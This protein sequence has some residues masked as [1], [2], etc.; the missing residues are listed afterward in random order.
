M[1]RPSRFLVRLLPSVLCAW[2]APATAAD[3]VPVPG[4]TLPAAAALSVHSD[5]AQL[6]YRLE[7]AAGRFRV[8]IPARVAGEL[9]VRG[10]TA[11]S[12]ATEHATLP[13]PALPPGLLALLPARNQFA[14]AVARHEQAQALCERTRAAVAARLPALANAPGVD[15]AAWQ[16]AIDGWSKLRAETDAELARLERQRL[17]L[18]DQARALAVAG[19][20]APALLSLPE[21]TGGA[22]TTVPLVV[23]ADEL[24][25]AWAA[26]PL[27]EVA[28]RWLLVDLAAAATVT[29]C[30]ERF[31]VTWTPAAELYVAAD[32]HARLVRLARI[33]KPTGLALGTIATAVSTEPLDRGMV[34]PPEIRVQ[35]VG[36]DIRRSTGRRVASGSTSADWER[37]KAA[38]AAAA[39]AGGKEATVGAQLGKIV[40]AEQADSVHDVLTAGQNAPPM[41]MDRI[42]DQAAHDPALRRSSDVPRLAQDGDER[43]WEV[44]PIALPEGVASVAATLA[45]GAVAVQAD[46][47]VLIPVQSPVAIRRLALRLDDQPLLAGPLTLLVDGVPLATERAPF[48]GPGALLHVRGAEDDA[49]FTPAST[50]WKVPPEEQTERHQRQGGDRTVRNLGTERRTV[51]FYATIPISRS[52]ELVVDVDAA[53]TPG[54]E[55]VEPG[56][57]R[58]SLVLEPGAEKTVAVGYVLQASGGFKL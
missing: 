36:E 43:Q 32:G 28:T 25:R 37:A 44:G 53:T 39:V 12:V 30:E 49:V 18:A 26:Q 20:D 23:S 41:A 19:G 45:S 21:A 6:I 55:V 13:L 17:E 5:G 2:G 33:A 40:A 48:A 57:L 8:A 34:A 46:E 11:W 10:A 31:D 52:K 51:R 50:P 42:A 15:G 35:V 54:Y 29:I 56:V 16:A 27:P 22:G 47:W 1:I 7:L 58:W 4:L 3:V 14:A 9:S 24:A 38:P